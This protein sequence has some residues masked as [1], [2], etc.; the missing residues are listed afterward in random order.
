MSVTAANF[1]LVPNINFIYIAAYPKIQMS[2]RTVNTLQGTES[3]Y[4][5]NKFRVKRRL[6]LDL[7]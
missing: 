4:A 7:C 2:P 3:W 6:L 5:A 1:I